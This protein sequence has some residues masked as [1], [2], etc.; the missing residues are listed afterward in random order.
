MENVKF[1][2]IGGV[3]GVGKTYVRDALVEKYPEK[4]CSIKQVTTRARREGEL[5]DAYL[6]LTKDEYDKMQHSLIGRT[7]I[8]GNYYGSIIEE[9]EERICIIILN[10]EGIRDFRKIKTLEDNSL[11][12]ALDKPIDQLEV[13]R[14]GRDNKHLINE[15][16]IRDVCDITINL[17]NG[18]YVS[19]EEIDNLVDFY[20]LKH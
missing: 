13:R 17:L 3:S 18:R 1:L 15:R 10:E 6:F 8:N 4:Y 14:E 7:E 5:E 19:L 9:G 16:N 11:F 20:L 2:V 12:I